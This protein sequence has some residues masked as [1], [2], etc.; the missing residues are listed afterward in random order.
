MRLAT[1]H[2]SNLT[3]TCQIGSRC[4]EVGSARLPRRDHQSKCIVCSGCVCRGG[5]EALSHGAGR[6]VSNAGPLAL[7][8]VS[9]HGPTRRRPR[10][11]YGH[12]QS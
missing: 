3:Q 9:P 12:L 5:D 11:W 6:A 1:K 7:A 10:G 8:R 2:R 4:S